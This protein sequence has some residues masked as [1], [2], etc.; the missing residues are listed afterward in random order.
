[1]FHLELGIGIP[2]LAAGIGIEV[3]ISSFV[4]RHSTYSIVLN[5][6]IF[7]FRFVVC[8]VVAF[9]LVQLTIIRVSFPA[10]AGLNFVTQR[11]CLGL[12]ISVGALGS[13]C[14][15]FSRSFVRS[16]VCCVF[17]FVVAM[18]NIFFFFV[19]CSG[20]RIYLWAR[21]GLCKGW[22][23]ICIKLSKVSHSFFVVFGLCC[24]ILLV[25]FHE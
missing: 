19:I 9:S 24:F 23:K 18:F 11:P 2:V 20:G 5:I 4:A 14:L 17:M 16:F 22:I 6:I 3:N 10:S 21:I 12:G 7:C 25:L 1:M 13:F 15:F 8:I